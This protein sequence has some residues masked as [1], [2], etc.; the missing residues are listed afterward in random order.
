MKKQR[1]AYVLCGT[2]RSGSTLICEMLAASGVAGRPNSFFREA[3]VAYWA[4]KWGVP[5]SV[6][7]ESAEFDRAYLA[8]MREAGRAGTGI[9]GL[10]IMFSSLVDAKRRLDRAAGV[11]RDVAGHLA[12]AFGTPLYI[13]LSRQNKLAQAVSLARA[14]QTGL[15]HLNAD[16]TVLE[17]TG[18]PAEPAYDGA[19]IAAILAQLERDDQAWEEF[20]ADRRLEPLRLSYE[21]VVEAPQ[22]ALAQ[23][24]ERL[25][26]DPLLANTIAVPTAKMADDISRQW[27]ERFER[28]RLQAASGQAKGVAW[29]TPLDS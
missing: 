27:A 21:T 24:L 22:Q 14:L 12:A 19:R 1:L 3:D 11:D 18:A 20:F 2:P 26:L 4:E 16:G 7:I 23:I 13:H 10:R 17:G 29:A 5:V 28:E 9:F 6:G 25:G 15:W 8:A